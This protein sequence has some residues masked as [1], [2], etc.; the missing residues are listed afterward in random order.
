MQMN[1]TLQ[2][3]KLT[4]HNYNT[5]TLMK[6]SRNLKKYFAHYVCNFIQANTPSKGLKKNLHIKHKIEKL[7][8]Q[9]LL[10]LCN[11]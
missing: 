4:H 6:I 7:N 3:C 9:E 8:T 10:T 2:L 11:Y 1:L 5:L